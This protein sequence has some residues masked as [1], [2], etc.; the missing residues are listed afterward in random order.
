MNVDVV[1][2]LHLLLEHFQI[3]LFLFN[4]ISP[5]R[6]IDKKENRIRLFHGF[7]SCFGGLFLFDW[8]Q[9]L[10]ED[11]ALTQEELDHVLLLL[12]L[13]HEVKGFVRLWNGTKHMI[14]TCSEEFSSWLRL[15]AF[16]SFSPFISMS[17]DSISILDLI[18]SSLSSSEMDGWLAL[19]ILDTLSSYGGQWPLSI[20]STYI[21]ARGMELVLCS[22]HNLLG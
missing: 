10:L 14:F 2:R 5:S 16:S 9:K 3:I 4:A 12:T 15:L 19:I 7:W 6:T 17:S 21:Q 8:S 20:Y 13:A 18:L 11:I 22:F 1:H